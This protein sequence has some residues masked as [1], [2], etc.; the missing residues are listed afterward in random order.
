MRRRLRILHESSRTRAHSHPTD[1]STREPPPYASSVLSAS[2]DPHGTPPDTQPDAASPLVAQKSFPSCRLD[3]HHTTAASLRSWRSTAK[4]HPRLLT[5]SRHDK[6]F[7]FYVAQLRW[8]CPPLHLCRPRSRREARPLL[9]LAGAEALPTVS[10]TKAAFIS[11]Y[12]KVGLMVCVCYSTLVVACGPSVTPTGGGVCWR[13]QPIPAMFNTVLQEM[14]V[15]QHMTRYNA[16]YS[17][18]SVRPASWRRLSPPRPTPAH[19]TQRQTAYAFCVCTLPPH[20]E[21]PPKTT[22]VRWPVA[23]PSAGLCVGVRPDFRWLQV[24]QCGGHLQVSIPSPSSLAPCLILAPPR[25]CSVR[26]TSVMRWRLF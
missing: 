13:A 25:T 26:C 23:D 8:L 17:Y 12:S 16:K 18:N 6:R 1:E 20:A 19:A 15:M 9:S 3:G 14:I 7:G 2:G 10:E 4:T 22:R 21:C 24:G 5:P 11:A